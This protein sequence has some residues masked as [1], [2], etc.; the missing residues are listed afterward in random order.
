M[1]VMVSRKKC[2]DVVSV[3]IDRSHFK[4]ANSL[5]MQHNNNEQFK[6]AP[7]LEWQHDRVMI[8]SFLSFLNYSH[9]F[10]VQSL[11]LLSFAA[12]SLSTIARTTSSTSNR[13]QTAAHGTFR[14]YTR[15]PKLSLPTKICCTFCF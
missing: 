7:S 4:H 1:Q 10:S 14:T 13:V 11:F 6:E 12:D 8:D 2:P 15:A 3:D 9:L 5:S